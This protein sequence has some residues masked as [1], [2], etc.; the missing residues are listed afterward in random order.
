M[1]ARDLGVNKAYEPVEDQ[2]ATLRPGTLEQI[3]GQR[4]AVAQLKLLCEAAQ[5]RGEPVCHLL[6]SG[7]P[8]LGKT[9]L[10]YAVAAEMG[11][12]PFATIGQSIGPETLG[13][14]LGSGVEGRLIFIDEIQTLSK[15]C[16]TLLLGALEDGWV[17]VS[18]PVGPQRRLVLPFTLVGAT[19]NPGS[20]SEPLKTRFGHTVELSYYGFSDL[21]RLA[22]R[23]AVG[24][25]MALTKDGLAAVADRSKGTPRT[26]NVLML[27]LR[28][29]HA[30]HGNDGKIDQSFVDRALAYFGI[31]SLGLGQADRDYLTVLHTRFRDGPIGESQLAVQ[32]G[33]DTRT[34]RED[35]E[36]FLL[37]IGL[38]GRAPRGRVL[39]PDG[40]AYVRE[41]ME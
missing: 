26:T 11:A 18:T 27:R 13:K 37:R 36:P 16:Q 14:L 35:I 34:I 20:L 7:P 23:T 9:S 19:T 24:L 8:G 5:Q 31:D 12:T 30:V 33:M 4:E 29:F 3:V 32:L 41:L 22:T 15:A 1:R 39:M 25:G 40:I 2:Q 17:D 28:D 21:E 6:L 38:I 10:A